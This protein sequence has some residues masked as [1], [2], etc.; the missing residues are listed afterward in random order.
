MF[1]EAILL[2]QEGVNPN[3]LVSKLV[4]YLTDDQAKALEGI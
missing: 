1:I 4:S 3:T 2:I